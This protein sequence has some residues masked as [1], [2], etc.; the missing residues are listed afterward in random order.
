MTSPQS[1]PKL[2]VLQLDTT[3]PRPPG[4]V[5]HPQS[6]PFPIAVGVVQEAN[7]T[8]IVSGTWGPEVV[9][10]FVAKAEQMRAEEGCVAFITSCGFLAT[11]HP[12]LAARVPLIGTSSLLQ[13]T[14]LQ[15]LFFPGPEHAVGVITFRRSA[16]VSTGCSSACAKSLTG[17]I[18]RA[19]SR[20]C[21]CTP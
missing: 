16:L 15:N 2:G 21:R 5:S 17:L 6:W 18:D 19:T 1:T 14:W 10:A 20:Q 12:Q 4:D 9:D 3:F 8:N 11:M 13:V 7:T